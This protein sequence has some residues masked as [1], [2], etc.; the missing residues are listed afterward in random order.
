VPVVG[1]HLAGS[2]PFC[3]PP[4]L[5]SIPLDAHSKTEFLFW[6]PERK[7]TSGSCGGAKF[8]ASKVEGRKTDFRGLGPAFDSCNALPA[9]HNSDT[10]CVFAQSLGRNGLVE[11]ERWRGDGARKSD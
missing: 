8:V 9:N 7:A 4:E 11:L 5:Q 10:G 3:A 2:P 1:H 6:A